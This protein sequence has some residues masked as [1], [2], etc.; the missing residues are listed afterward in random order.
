M[1]CKN[2]TIKVRGTVFNTLSIAP[3]EAELTCI[4]TNDD[5]GK[6]LSIDN[7]IFQFSIPFEAIEEYLK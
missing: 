2:K 6:T 5:T 3:R 1:K 7:G 4:I